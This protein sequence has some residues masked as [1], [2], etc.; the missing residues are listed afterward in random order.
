MFGL[1]LK[2]LVRLWECILFV[3][4]ASLFVFSWLRNEGRRTG[5]KC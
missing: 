5:D 4:V 3:R 2:S 1:K